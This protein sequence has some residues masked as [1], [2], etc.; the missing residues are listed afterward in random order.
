[1]KGAGI[2]VI[3]TNHIID[4][5]NRMEEY[6]VTGVRWRMGDNLTMEEMTEKAE[7][8]I[9]SL[10]VGTK[11]IL[12]AE[13][14]N[15]HDSEAI[16]V[17]MDYT[18]HVGYIKHECCKEV[19]KLLNTY[20]QCDAVVSGNDGHVTFFVEIPDAPE[21]DVSPYNEEPKLPEYPLPQSVRL[22]FSR[23]EQALQVVAPRIVGTQV[24]AETVNDL[25]VM[26][27]RYMPLS[28]LS[29]CYEDNYWRDHVLRQLRKA[30]KLNLSQEQKTRLEQLRD[31]L[32]DKV[33]DFH[34]SHT[35]WEQSLF[36]QQL[37][38]LRKQTGGED[39]FFARF[40]KYIKDSNI[41]L[42]VV[43]ARMQ[44]WFKDMPHVNLRNYNDH[45]QV[46]KTLNYLG[47]S[48]WEL[49]NIY[50]I[51]LLLER[52]KDLLLNDSDKELI[53]KLT[54]IFYNNENEATNFL[55]SV[56][57]MKSTQ[58]TALVNQLV[59]EKKISDLSKN[60]DLWSLLYEA[61]IYNKTESNWNQQMK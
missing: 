6:E 28:G 35:R 10:K 47:V 17:Y 14:D 31:G 38:S 9:R 1:M 5:K 29:F 32:N 24:S 8:F 3:L 46:A 45:H 34:S 52:H 26:A 16:A 51:L 53:K 19:K 15:P 60:R 12:M 36:D 20:R 54:P 42:R 4:G 44:A 22:A 13:P 33:G 41:N 2:L 40:D 61:G 49:Y 50:G 11:M 7:D 25:L 58:I 30:C 43:V 37:E 55:A 39:G 23:E 21:L 27:E 48:R 59:T 57:G 18:R 56:K